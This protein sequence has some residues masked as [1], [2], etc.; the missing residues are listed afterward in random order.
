MLSGISLTC[1]AGSYIIAFLF[2]VSRLRLRGGI[3]HG[4]AMVVTGI[5]LLVHSIHLYNLATAE[6][7]MGSGVLSSWYDW[8][9]VAAWV[10]A[11]AYFGMSLRRPETALGIF[12]MPLIL[13]LLGGAMLFQQIAPEPFPQDD[14]RRYWRVIHGIA[15]LMGTVSVLLGFATGLMYLIQAYRLKHKL[16]PRLGFQLPSLEWLHRC[17]QETLFVSTLLLAVGVLSGVVLNLYRTQQVAWTDPVVFS[18]VVLFVWLTAAS[19]F[20]WFYKPAREGHKV[21][22]LTVASLG[23]L[24]LALMLALVGRHAVS[25]KEN[26]A[27]PAS[28]HAANTPDEPGAREVE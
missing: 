1:I 12:F 15:L 6:A 8:C 21:A 14:G 5:G 25:L 18:S 22:Y 28:V 3:W 20:E 10:L 24:V 7:N 26:G 2:E 19:L 9:L 27:L 4:I 23:F 13:A 11:A 16:P 17:S